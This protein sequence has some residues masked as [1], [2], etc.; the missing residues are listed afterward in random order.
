MYKYRW[1]CRWCSSEYKPLKET[2]RDGFCKGACKQA[3]Y[4]AYKHYV[5]A[6]A[7]L[8]STPAAMSVTKTKRKKKK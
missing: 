8:I 7:W 2:D 4:R 1:Y 3:H 5:T 6:V